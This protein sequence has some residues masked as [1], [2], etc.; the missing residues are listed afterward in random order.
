MLMWCP[1]GVPMIIAAPFMFSGRSVR[2]HPLKR[3][4]KF[5]DHIDG[6]RNYL[7]ND[8]AYSER[9]KGE[10]FILWVCRPFN[11]EQA[12]AGNGSMVGFMAQSRAEVDAFYEAAMTDGGTDEGASGLR[13]HYGP[14]WY[15]AYA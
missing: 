10:G 8:R 7:K 11:G 9:G 1:A 13:P 6:K 4:N 2:F 14:N 12:S 5:S 3:L 15:S